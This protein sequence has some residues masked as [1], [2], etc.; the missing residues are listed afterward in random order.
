MHAVQWSALVRHVSHHITFNA[1][2][3]YLLGWAKCIAGASCDVA[4]GA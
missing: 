2:G 1:V 3:L 4:P